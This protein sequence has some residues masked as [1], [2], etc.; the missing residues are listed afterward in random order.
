MSASPLEADIRP[1]QLHVDFGPAATIVAD[2]SPG[3][4][5]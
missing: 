3:L 4:G 2:H 5:G 1:R